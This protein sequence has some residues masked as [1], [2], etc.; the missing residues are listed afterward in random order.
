MI[1]YCFLP[2]YVL[3]GDELLAAHLPPSN[4]DAA[5]HARAVVKLLVD[6]LCTTRPDV[7]ITIRDDSGFC[8][9]QL[10]RWCDSRGIGYVLGL[11]KNP[12]L[13]RAAA[14]EIARAERQ[15]HKT[16]HPQRL[17]GRSSY[18]VAS[19]DRPR[20][21]VVKPE[22]NARG[23][24]PRFI[25]ANEPGDPQVLYDDV[26]CQRSEMENRIKEQ[27]LDLFA[28][29]TSCHRFLV[30]QLRLLL[31]A[32][33]YV[34]VQALRRMALPGT[35]LA[36]AQVGTIRL[37][38]LKVAARVAISARRVVFHLA[39]SC[40]YRGCW[41]RCTSFRT[42]AHRPWSPRGDERSRR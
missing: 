28:D 22:H 2:L 26:Y 3:R 36:R 4:I 9:W 18:A 34:L 17:S 1:N 32:A 20:R 39:S 29:R 11:V 25:V 21:I 42:A 41:R 15:F 10:M 16:G 13:L 14:D 33:A 31:I 24:N 7:R 30:N 6:R 8:R 23:A 12:A 27:Q 38:L 35:E 37:R 5:R 19:W 40:P